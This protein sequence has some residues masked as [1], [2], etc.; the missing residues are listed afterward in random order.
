MYKVTK[1]LLSFKL[2]REA[3]ENFSEIYNHEQD[4]TST[5]L[6]MPHFELFQHLLTIIYADMV[7][8]EDLF[9][10]LPL[11]VEEDYRIGTNAVALGNLMKQSPHSVRRQLSRLIDAGVI[12]AKINHGNNRNFELLIN[13][14]LLLIGDVNNPNYKANSKFL[15][16]E[17]MSLKTSESTRCSLL[18]IDNRNTLSNQ[19]IHCELVD[20]YILE[21]VKHKAE[22]E[23]KE[24]GAGKPANTQPKPSDRYTQK[25]FNVDDTA[26]EKTEILSPKQTE[27][28]TLK[29]LPQKFTT[30]VIKRQKTKLS[31]E[32]LKTMTLDRYKVMM[33]NWLLAYALAKL[34]ADKEIYK[35]EYIKAH[36]HILDH[37]W[38]GL[39][40]YADFRRKEMELRWRIDAV[41]RYIEHNNYKMVVYPFKYFDLS[42]V[43]SGFIQTKAWYEID[44][45]RQEK[46]ALKKQRLS[47]IN[48]IQNAVIAYAKNP[49][50]DEYHKQEAYVLANVGYLKHEFYQRII[51]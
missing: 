32:Q 48:K 49:T 25:Q 21:N 45:K 20:K 30:N 26:K 34:W 16:N 44:K 2:S 29:N 47:D 27:P 3:Y 4:S 15:R 17:K 38:Q 35:A 9:A 28:D 19:L 1:P 33:T 6:R 24:K 31:A 37:Y 18:D 11:N 23:P 14:E 41:A 36:Q 22:A 42:N 13:H 43:T 50:L 5:K 46:K 39:S 51:S 7:R 10:I 12:T 8:N 40:T